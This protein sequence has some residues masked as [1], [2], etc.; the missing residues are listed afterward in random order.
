MKTATL[1]RLLADQKAKTPVALVTDLATGEEA[2]VYYDSASGALKDRPSAVAAA[3][4]ALRD[5]KSRT[6]STPEG[7]IFVHVFNPPLRMVLVGAVHIAQPL[8][9]MAAV[10]GYDVFVG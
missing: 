3:R 4:D 6:V 2:L 8:S 5:D 9:R 7:D 1:T 10:A